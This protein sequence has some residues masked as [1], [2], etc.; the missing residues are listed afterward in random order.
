MIIEIAVDMDGVLSD[1]RKKYREIFKTDPEEDY[2]TTDE[3]RKVAHQ[4]R[5]HKFIEDGHFEYLEP[6]PDL[7]LG[8]EFLS[9]LDIPIYILTS[10]AREEYMRS[11]SS[12]KRKWLKQYNI[13]YNP[14]FVP[15]KRIKCYY[16]KPNKVLI[17]DTKSNIDDWNSNSGIGI[18]H[19]SWEQSINTLKEYL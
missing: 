16:A 6:M 2:N 7:Q 3:T 17:D 18:H 12:Q 13:Q 15:G 4:H 10:V 1:F 11:L 9:S 19:K 5:F 8:L 14:V